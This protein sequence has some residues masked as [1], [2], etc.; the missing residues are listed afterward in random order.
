M[1]RDDCRV[2]V[3]PVAV[4]GGQVDAVEPTTDRAHAQP[5]LEAVAEPFADPAHVRVVATGHRP[6]AKAAEAEHAV[7][8]EKADR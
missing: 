2:E 7:I 4:G 5:E 3:M 8:L 6:P 1:R